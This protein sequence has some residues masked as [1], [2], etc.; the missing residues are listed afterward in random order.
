MKPIHHSILTAGAGLISI[1]ISKNQNNIHSRCNDKTPKIYY[2]GFF[3][4]KP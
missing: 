3:I 2:R 1:R 4:M